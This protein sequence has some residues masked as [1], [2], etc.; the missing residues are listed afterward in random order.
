[1]D[2]LTPMDW[3]VIVAGVLAIALGAAWGWR[4]RNRSDADLF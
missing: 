3:A 2:D 4:V 1:M